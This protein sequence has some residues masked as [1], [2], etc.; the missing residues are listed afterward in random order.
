MLSSGLQLRIEKLVYGGAGLGRFNG[1]VNLTPFVLPGEVVE[2][3]PLELRRHVRQTHLT[4]VIEPSIDRVAPPCPYFG[5]CGGCHYQHASY[6]AQLRAKREILAETLCRI[7]KINFESS[8]ICIE[9]ASPFGYRNRVQLHT[10]HRAIGY[11]E[12]HSARLVAVDQCPISSPKIN[13]IIAALN[14]LVRDRRWPD[15]IR[16]IE[17]FTNERDVQWNILEADK[18]VAKRFFEWLAE[19]VAGTVGGVLNYELNGDRFAVSGNSFFQVNRFLLPRM[20]ET[21]LKAAH[22]KV[23]WDLYAGVGLFSLPLSRNFDRVIAVESGR[24]ASH[25][26]RRNAERATRNIE[27]VAESVETFVDRADERP[28]FVLADP[29][30]A[31]LGKAVV[32]RLLDLRP[33][34]L[35]IVACDPATLARDLQPLSSAYEVAGLTLIDL[36]PQTFHIETVA[37]LQLRG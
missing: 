5:R 36:F 10:A 21:A 7:G 29:P 33:P 19:E 3:E 20:A 13:E 11:R 8:G 14:R 18:P 12:M 28:D 27:V 17:I 32:S 35:V 26:L 34:G 2:A 24:Y 9:S 4:A 22:G 6:D 31:G 15:F 25:D 23:A 30:R 37:K 16:V 1:E